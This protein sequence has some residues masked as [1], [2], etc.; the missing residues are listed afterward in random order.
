MGLVKT[1]SGKHLY[2]VYAYHK[3]DADTMRTQ[4][5]KKYRAFWVDNVYLPYTNIL[6]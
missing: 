6:S 2:K 3:G 4:C 5:N 1:C